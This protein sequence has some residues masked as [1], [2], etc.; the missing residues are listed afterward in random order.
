MLPHVL[1]QHLMAKTGKSTL[2]IAKDMHRASFQSTL[3]KFVHGDI[4]VPTHGTAKR[5]ADYFDLPIEAMY[6]SKVAAKYAQERG[7]AYQPG[8]PSSLAI[9]AHEEAPTKLT[10]KATV[11]QLPAATLA[12]ISSLN[13]EQFSALDLMITSYLNTVAPEASMSKELRG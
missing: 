12:R 4:T 11:R 5:I 2:Q 3:H 6:D 1:I 9:H 8:T 10:P 7:L 13:K